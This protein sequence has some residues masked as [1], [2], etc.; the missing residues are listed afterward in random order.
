MSSEKNQSNSNRTPYLPPGTV[1]TETDLRS[2]YIGRLPDD[3]V[4]SDLRKMFGSCGDIKRCT[5]VKNM[6]SG[7]SK[8]VAFLEFADRSAV[9]AALALNGTNLKGSSLSV[10][11]KRTRSDRDYN[12]PQ[13]SPYYRPGMPPNPAMMNPAMMMAAAAY[14]PMQAAMMRS[15]MARGGMNPSPNRY[16][17]G[18]R[19]PPPPQAY[20]QWGPPPNA[21]DMDQ[22]NVNYEE[23]DGLWAAPACDPS[24]ERWNRNEWSSPVSSEWGHRGGRGGGQRGSGYSRGSRSAAAPIDGSQAVAGTPTNHAYNGQYRYPVADSNRYW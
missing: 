4:E 19:R 15:M 23:D 20:D 21:A 5:I 18:M 8:G 6:K 2:V 1:I 9:T 24:N 11:E 12:T 17:R 10:V 14:W 13:T 3:V 22:H 7:S 16:M